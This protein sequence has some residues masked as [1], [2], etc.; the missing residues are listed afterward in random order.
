[1][2]GAIG[3]IDSWH[4]RG[5][6][7]EQKTPYVLAII[8]ADTISTRLRAS[9]LEVE[10]SISTWPQLG[11]A[12]AMGGGAAADVA[13]RILLG[14][15][16]V[17]GRFFLDLEDVIPNSISIP[18]NSAAAAVKA[19]IASFRDMVGLLPRQEPP[20]TISAERLNNLVEAASLAP[21]GGNSQPWRWIWS[22]NR[23]HLFLDTSRSRSLLD[24]DSLAS[25]AALGA[26]TE[27]LVL[28]AHA[29][30][31]GVPVQEFTLGT[32][33]PLTAIFDFCERG[34]ADDASSIADGLAP[35]IPVR[36][37]N[38]R[39]ATRQALSSILLTELDRSVEG[40]PGARLRWLLTD[41]EL[42]EAARMLGIGDRLIFL[43]PKLH[44]EVMAE[45]V[46]EPG[47]AAHAGT[48]IP[49]ESLELSAVDRAGLEICRS[50]PALAL[51]RQWRG[52]RNLEK[53]ARKAIAVSSAVGMLTQNHSGKIDY[54]H[55]GRAM[56]RFWL[57]ATRLGLAVQPLTALAY[58]FTRMLHGG[59]DELDG[60]TLDE[61]RQLWPAWKKLFG[62]KSHEAEILVFRI[63]F[64][65]PPSARSLRRP[66]A[67]ILDTF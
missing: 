65:D 45:I 2:H 12:V 49:V 41:A 15:S 38:R 22:G 64:A 63:S 62:L 66:V 46:F 30:D 43:N 35:Y 40:L 25:V 7:T 51:L 19:P 23:L 32:Q 21:S 53:G 55:G 44:S 14:Q 28:C 16:M 10:Q 36:V 56:Q 67:E 37:T 1:L 11:S 26:A 29:A 34:R 3:D 42:N 48:G 54:F 33:E 13:R 52:G 18:S 59:G 5:L 57:T 47:D 24:F 50:G 4:L 6:T 31:V 27:N 9:L 8:G 61:L 17:S 58:L 60:D 39:H 20:W